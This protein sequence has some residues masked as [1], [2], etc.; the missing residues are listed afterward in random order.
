MDSITSDVIAQVLNAVSVGILPT[1]V[2][3][4]V[5]WLPTC[6]VIL[7]LQSAAPEA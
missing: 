5:L 2:A 3:F 4:I 1:A 7:L 6:C